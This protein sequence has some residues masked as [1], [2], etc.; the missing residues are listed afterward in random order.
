MDAHREKDEE[1]Y[2]MKAEERDDILNRVM[3]VLVEEEGG[4][5]VLR[6][7]CGSSGTT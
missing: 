5:M 3:G 4:K 1:D 2:E 6:V 7:V